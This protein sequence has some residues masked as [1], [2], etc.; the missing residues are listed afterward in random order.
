MVW[1]NCYN[2]IDPALPYGGVK[3]SGWGRE[4]GR[5]AIEMYTELK[6]VYMQV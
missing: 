5:S 4:M 6:T 1:V 2:V 3:T